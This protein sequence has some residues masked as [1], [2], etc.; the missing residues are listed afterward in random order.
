[1]FSATEIPE[2]E[3]GEDADG[4]EAACD[5]ADGGRA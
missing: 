1:M 5:G 3:G 2:Q 4:C